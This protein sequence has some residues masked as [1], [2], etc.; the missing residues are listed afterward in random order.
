MKFR[1]IDALLSIL[2]LSMVLVAAIA[3]SSYIVD[4]APY[5]GAPLAVTVA[6]S[7]A[8]SVFLVTS[9]ELWLIRTFVPL[10]EG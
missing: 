3:I 1:F 9:A 4:L 6:A 10:I 2:S 8:A 7:C 5:S